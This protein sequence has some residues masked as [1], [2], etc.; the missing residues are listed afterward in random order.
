AVEP[1]VCEEEGVPVLGLTERSE[2][3]VIARSTVR[4]GRG[5]SVDQGRGWSLLGH[6]ALKIRVREA[7]GGG[8]V[9]R[10]ISR[11]PPVVN[12]PSVPD[13]RGRVQGKSGSL[14]GGT[15]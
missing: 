11:K 2:G 15:R 3:S 8:Q 5:V 9:S 7:G 12:I 14:V 1:W 10:P 13:S 4:T 6:A